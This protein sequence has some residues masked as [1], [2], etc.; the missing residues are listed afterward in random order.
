MQ[1]LGVRSSSDRQAL[2]DRSTLSGA[3]FRLAAVFAC[4]GIIQLLA[5]W[6]LR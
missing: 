4:A 3:I 2:P 1:P 6:F 5:S